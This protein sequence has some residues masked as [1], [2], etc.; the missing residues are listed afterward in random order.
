MSIKKWRRKIF[1]M[2]MARSRTVETAGVDISHRFLST[3]IPL[4][5]V[6]KYGNG[7]RY[8]VNGNQRLRSA[9][10]SL[11]TS[12]CWLLVLI[13]EPKLCASRSDHSIP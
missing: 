13:C 12:G 4:C 2:R 1:A 6:R 8:V 10:T 5:D 9:T 3:L 7:E 11:R